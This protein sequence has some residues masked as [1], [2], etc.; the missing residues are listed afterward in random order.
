MLIF[1][2]VAKMVL[3]KH[4][5]EMDIF[6]LET[7]CDECKKVIFFVKLHLKKFFPKKLQVP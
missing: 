4:Q 3:E 1:P 2:N 5:K 7:G 6:C